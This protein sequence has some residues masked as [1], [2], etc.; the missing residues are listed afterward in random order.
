MSKQT[1]TPAERLDVY[2]ALLATYEVKE[3]IEGVRHGFCSALDDLEFYK[4]GIGIDFDELTELHAQLPAE[5]FDRWYYFPIV[6]FSNKRDDNRCKALYA[7]IEL[8]YKNNPELY[9]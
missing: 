2:Y 9:V 8:V 5:K 4:E 7:A 3:P 6:G 1:L